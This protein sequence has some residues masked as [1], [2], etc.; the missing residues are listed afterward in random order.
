MPRGAWLFLLVVAL[1][2]LAHTA[3]NTATFLISPPLIY[4]DA[5]D[6]ADAAYDAD[7]YADGYDADPYDDDLYDDDARSP[8]HDLYD[9]E[10]DAVAFEERDGLAADDAE[11]DEGGRDEPSAPDERELAPWC[12]DR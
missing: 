1:L 12:S 9:D 4:V 10:H 2:G 3:W 8:D 5:S 7:P 11:R 6:L